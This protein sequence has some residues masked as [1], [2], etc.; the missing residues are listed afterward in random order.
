M[1][2]TEQRTQ[3]GRGDLLAVAEPWLRDF[4]SSIFGALIA[5][6]LVILSAVL[7]IG[8]VDVLVKI[9][10]AGTAMALAPRRARS[11][12][13][14]RLTDVRSVRRSRSG[15][16][17]EGRLNVIALRNTAGL[18][19]VTFLLTVVGL[20]GAVW[21]IAS[22]IAVAFLVALA[23]SLATFALAAAQLGAFGSR[24]PQ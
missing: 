12:S 9:A 8:S 23:A 2:E 14:P 13:A 11:A 19:S 5:L 18:L 10:T 20:T 3:M 1:T 21:H 6:N 24:P 15:K 17:E 4:G 22:S 7:T 16:P